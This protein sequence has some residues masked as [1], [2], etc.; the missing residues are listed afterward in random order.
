MNT[1]HWDYDVQTVATQESRTL[2]GAYCLLAL[3][4]KG[5]HQPSKNLIFLS[6]DMQKEICSKQLFIG[7]FCN[8]VKS[9]VNE[10]AL[11]KTIIG[12]HR[13]TM[14]RIWSANC[15]TF[16]YK[17]LKRKVLWAVSTY[18]VI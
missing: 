18:N 14:D 1:K 16:I 7:H 11:V 9:S 3:K 12:F 8:Q 15:F 4:S 5:L 10:C 2:V 17:H 13:T 6:I